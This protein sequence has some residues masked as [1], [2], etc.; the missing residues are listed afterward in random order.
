ME[1]FK[2]EENTPSAQEFG[3]EV[4]CFAQNDFFPHFFHFF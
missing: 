1:N 2:E 4:R 3:R